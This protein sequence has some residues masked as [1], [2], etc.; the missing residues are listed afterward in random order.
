MVLIHFRNEP[1]EVVYLHWNK[2]ER[3][4]RKTMDVI[5]IHLTYVA[6]RLAPEK[7]NWKVL[8]GPV[9]QTQHHVFSVQEHY[10]NII[11]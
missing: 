1:A 2:K 5:S 7:G 4:G 6:L 11:I 3:T 8:L 10:I 9:V